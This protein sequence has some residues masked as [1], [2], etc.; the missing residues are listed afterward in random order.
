VPFVVRQGAAGIIIL[1]RH[2]DPP[3]G[4]TYYENVSQVVDRQQTAVYTLPR[5]LKRGAR[6]TMIGAEQRFK[7]Q[8]VP[9]EPFFNAR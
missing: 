4:K 3:V 7:R 8:T 9:P 6:I 2:Q 5:C 1:Q